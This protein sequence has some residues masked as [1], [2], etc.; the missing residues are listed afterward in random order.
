MK[1]VELESRLNGGDPTVNQPTP[2]ATPSSATLSGISEPLGPQIPTFGQPQ[3]I[4][5]HA[6]QNRFPAIAFLDAEAFKYGGYE[7]TFRES[8]PSC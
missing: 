1:V 7:E 2:F 4:S 5:W 6:V 8:K 3:E